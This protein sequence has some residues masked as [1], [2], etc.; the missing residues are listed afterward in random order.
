MTRTKYFSRSRSS[1]C[2]HPTKPKPTYKMKSLE[3]EDYSAAPDT[4]SHPLVLDLDA[5]IRERHSTRMF[6]PQQPV[7]RALVDEALALAQLAPS[8]SNI[9]PWRMVFA[10][11]PARARLVEALLEAAHRGHRT[12][13]PCQSPSSTSAANS[14]RKSTGRW[15][16]LARI[17]R[18][19]RLP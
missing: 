13:L 9:Q 18:A 4:P 2:V 7:P 17:R 19:G 1:A 5:A 15:E 14:A 11:G 8:N 10:T 3:L 6:L 12:S 16:S